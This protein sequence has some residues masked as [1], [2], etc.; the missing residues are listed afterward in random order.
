M[1]MKILI[2][3]CIYKQRYYLSYHQLKVIV[4]FLQDQ[5]NIELNVNE[6]YLFLNHF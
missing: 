1:V 2:I 4:E 5:I 3:V 6:I